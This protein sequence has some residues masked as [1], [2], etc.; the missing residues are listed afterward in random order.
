MVKV[1]TLEEMLKA[2]MHFGIGHRAG[3]RKWS[4]TSTRRDAGS[5]SS[6]SP[7]RR[8]CWRK[9]WS[10]CASCEREQD[11]PVRS[12]QEPGQEALQGS[13]RGAWHALCSERWLGGSLTNF[14][15]IK[16]AIRKYQDLVE[17]RASGKLDRYTK[18]ERLNFER[19]IGPPGKKG[20]RA[21]A[22]G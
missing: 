18:K 22:H 10:I 5:T 1:P 19:E 13:G 16:K 9:L 2:G 11:H 3:I 6:I 14:Q 4:P 12:H 15:V 8:R 20:R 17:K 21:D 7:N